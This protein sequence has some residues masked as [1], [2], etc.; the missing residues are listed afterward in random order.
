[1]TGNPIVYTTLP[2]DGLCGEGGMPG[3]QYICSGVY[4]PPVAVPPA[5]AGNPC[6][7][8]ATQC[9]NALGPANTNDITGLL[10]GS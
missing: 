5:P 10:G 3:V 7:G 4:S 2:A 8:T 6:A 9:L 1:M